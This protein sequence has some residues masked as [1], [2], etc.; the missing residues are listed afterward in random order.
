[1]VLVRFLVALLS[2]IGML[3]SAGALVLAV[4]LM[5][6]FPPFLI[7]VSIA[8]LIFISFSNHKPTL[9]RKV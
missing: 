9:K 3:A 6:R 2:F 5:L 1:M 8:C 7:A 4:I